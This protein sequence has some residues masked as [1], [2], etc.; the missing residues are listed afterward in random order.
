ML[1]GKRFDFREIIHSNGKENSDMSD[2]GRSRGTERWLV[3]LILDSE[4]RQIAKDTAT[5]DSGA[6]SRA[7]DMTIG[8]NA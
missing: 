7:S 2:D 5:I 4:M 6:G 8:S 1:G 3:R